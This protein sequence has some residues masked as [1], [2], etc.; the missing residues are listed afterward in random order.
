MLFIYCLL[1]Y[2]VTNSQ[3]NCI[4]LYSL[5]VMESNSLYLKLKQQNNLLFYKILNQAKLQAE[6]RLTA[7]PYLF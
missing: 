6:A 1:K 4:K 5:Y 3:N 2:E 7:S